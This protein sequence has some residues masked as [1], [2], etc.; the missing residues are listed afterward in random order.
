MR[1]I[2]FMLPSPLIELLEREQIAPSANAQQ[3][4]ILTSA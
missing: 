1:L 4:Q 3:M 2:E